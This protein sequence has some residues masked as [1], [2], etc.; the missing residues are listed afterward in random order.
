MVSVDLVHHPVRIKECNIRKVP[1][2]LL[3]LLFFILLRY[4]NAASDLSLMGV[5]SAGLIL[6]S[7][8][9]LVV[10]DCFV[11]LDPQSQNSTL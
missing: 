6:A 8:T 10:V 7:S 4:S 5:V 11:I 9:T 2:F 1:N 3:F